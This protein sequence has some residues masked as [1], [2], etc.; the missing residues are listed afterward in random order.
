MGQNETWKWTGVRE[1][2]ALLVA[3][4]ELT[5]YEIA[6]RHHLARATLGRWKRYPDFAARVEEHRATWREE[7]K[8]KGI[9]D[10]QNRV[11]AANA[12]HAMLNRIISERAVAAEMATVP[13]G[14]TGL[15]TRKTA[16]VKVYKVTDDGTGNPQR[17]MVEVEEYAVDTGL[18]HELRA[19]EDEVAK[20][21]G[22]LVEKREEKLDA[23][24]GY[25]AALR[26]FGKGNP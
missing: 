10:V 5:D 1:A 11:D 26:S 3:K 24:D 16:Y 4:D 6:T 19:H 23:T 18:L 7:I 17:E 2:V 9:A 25:L 14:T 22:Q 15:L 20:H 13:G 8:R 12:R 21:L